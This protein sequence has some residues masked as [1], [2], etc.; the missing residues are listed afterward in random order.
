[1]IQIFV[2]LLG[3][4]GLLMQPVRPD[5]SKIP[6]ISA[7]TRAAIQSDFDTIL[8]K[9]SYT[10]AVSPYGDWA[11]R[12]SKR[13]GTAYLARAALQ[14]CEHTAGLP[15]GLAV[16]QA[17]NVEAWIAKSEL[18]YSK[19]LSQSSLPFVSPRYTRR[20]VRGYLKAKR[21]KALAISR[22]GSWAYA[23]GKLTLF[24]AKRLAMKRCEENDGNRRRCFLF[25]AGKNV[26]FSAE[27]DIYP[28][29]R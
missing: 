5:V 28:D 13:E 21:K 4:G 8:C 2:S 9:K 20:L 25:A 11:S 3:I 26:L 6:Y 19:E 16:V 23:S 10:L 29:R 7:E 17:R 27:T 24:E 14:K 18:S 1:M 22:N 12:C 15:C